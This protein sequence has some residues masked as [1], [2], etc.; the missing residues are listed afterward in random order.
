MEGVGTVCSKTNKC[1]I[2]VK[3]YFV[4]YTGVYEH[5]CSD[6]HY[7]FVFCFM[8]YFILFILFLILFY[9]ILFICLFFV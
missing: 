9:C 5:V 8:L 6:R 1:S 3:Q 7:K 4:T 2:D